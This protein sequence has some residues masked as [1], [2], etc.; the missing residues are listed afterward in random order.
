MRRLTERGGRGELVAGCRRLIRDWEPGAAALV[1]AAP[2]GFQGPGCGED[3]EC[4]A[5]GRQ[6]LD[7]LQR[8]TPLWR[9]SAEA[10]PPLDRDVAGLRFLI[11]QS[12]FHIGDVLWLTPL[13][14]SLHRIFRRPAITVVGASGRRNG[15]GGQSHLSELL[16]YHPRA[17]ED[18][19]DGCSRLSPADPSTPRSSA[20][21]GAPRAAG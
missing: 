14:R 2:L 4:A 8:E 13:L 17:G 15:A 5:A 18:G 6:F 21:L 12:R 9:V 19:D 7:A 3:E 10:P 16:V 1:L 11:H 20:G